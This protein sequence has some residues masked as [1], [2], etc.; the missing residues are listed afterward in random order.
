MRRRARRHGGSTSS[1]MADVA[2]HA[3][4]S[5][6]SVSRVLNDPDQVSA[7][8]RA[9][10]ESAVAELR[11][12]RH[13]P[14]R[15]LAA[16]RSHTIGAIVPT[17]GVGI[18]AI[19]VEALQRRLDMLGHSLVVASSQFDPQIELRQL[20]T[21]LERGIDGVVLVGHRHRA[22]L[23]RL[24]EQTAT[25]YV[26]TYSHGKGSHPCVGFDHAEAIGRGV[27][28]LAQLGHRRFGIITIPTRDNDRMTQRLRGA[29]ARIAMRGLP[30]P[31]IVEA[32]YSIAD[33]RSA[34]R[35]IRQQA[36]GLTAILCTTDVHAIGVIAEARAQ[37]LD[38]PGEL[39]I[40][41][42]DDLE[43]AAEL[44]PPLTT[45]HVPAREIG[46]HAAEMLVARVRGRDTPAIIEVKA[47]LVVRGST[48]PARAR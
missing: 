41:G 38:V 29:V 28:L 24:L 17:L 19:G 32:P 18:F 8:L 33:G 10:V 39:S 45:I 7:E 16:R 6:A 46:E 43:I 4:V 3:A 13:G 23:H 31:A 48:G 40:T 1:T 11:Y 47:T 12:V 26:C 20:R 35:A 36:R 15:A 14:A 21:L 2:A 37:K 9:R 22:D 44:D 42:F 25:P 5:T 30:K 27:D 34:L